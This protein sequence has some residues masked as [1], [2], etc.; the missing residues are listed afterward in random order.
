MKKI[1]AAMIIAVVAVAGAFAAMTGMTVGT[2]NINLE[3][4]VTDT[5]TPA[6][7]F[8]VAGV[9]YAGTAISLGT[10]QNGFAA[11]ADGKEIVVYDM[12]YSN[13]LLDDTNK[14]YVT[15]I[16]PTVWMKGDIAGP[17][18]TDSTLTES[19]DFNNTKSSVTVNATNKT[20][21]VS[22][23][24]GIADYTTTPNPLA[25]FKLTWAAKDVEAGVYTASVTV[26]YTT[27]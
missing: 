19:T 16:M 1:L 11:E 26:A 21:K 3:Y 8:T 7:G 14:T 12:S 22:Y 20:I 13:S 4:T 10:N 2:N 6:V 17:T 18:I 15:L 23:K 27:F 9:D 25:S 5:F 24:A